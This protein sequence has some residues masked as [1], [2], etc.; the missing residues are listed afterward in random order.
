MKRDSSM[1]GPSG[2]GR[3]GA[4]L[5]T[6]WL[7][8]IPGAP[9]TANATAPANTTGAAN[10]TAPINATAPASAKTVNW[11]TT[12]SDSAFSQA[13]R[14]HKFVLLDLHAVWCHW[15][16]MMDT[17]TYADP[18]VQAA[19][20]KHYVAVSVDADS[21]PAL[22]SRYGDWGWPATIVLAADGTEI[23]KRRGYIAPAQMLSLLDA[24]VADPSPGPSVGTAL[25]VGNTSATSLA[26][27]D[28]AALSETA[29]ALYDMANAGWGT[30][31]KYLDASAMEWSFA[32]LDAGNQLAMTKVRRTLDANQNLIDPVWGGV[33]QYS[34]QVDWKSPHYEKLLSYQADD[35]RIYSEA[36]SRWHRKTDLEAAQKLYSY[37]T[38]FL[39]APDGG[40][41]VSQD[42]DVS[43]K[44]AG[45][46]FYA[47]DDAAR[48][49]AGMPKV[50]VH[51]YSRETGWA[52]RALC[53]YYD[54]TGDAAALTRAERG[55]KWALRARQIAGGGFS[56]D[57]IGGDHHDNGGGASHGGNG[58][59]HHDNGGGASHGGNGGDHHDNGGGASH[60]GNG[61]DHHD[62]GGGA[63]HGGN[64]GDHHDNG[65]GASHGG[66]AGDHHDNGGGASHG[67]NAS[68]AGH[69]STPSD[70]TSADLTAGATQSAG[71]SADQAT[72]APALPGPFLDDSVSMTQAFLALYR[73]TGNREWLK[74]AVATLNFI[75]T[76]LRDSRAG[77]MASSP[78]PNTRGVFREPVRDV[79]QNAAVARAASMLHHYTAAERHLHIARHAM[80]YLSA[81]AAAASDQFRPD[82]LLADHEL[83]VAP[84]HITIVGGKD[85]PAAQ[86]LHAAALQY[87]TEYL[88]VDWW[89]RRE[90]KLPD[91]SIT[92]P[93]LKRPAAFACTANACS[94]PVYEASEIQERVRS[95]L[96]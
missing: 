93:D 12:W 88:Q 42:A 74:A 50:D 84:I 2:K 73:S 46:E 61:G 8:W 23:V 37:L 95:V 66:N 41:Y 30:E 7:L 45:H 13:A 89:D 92:Y 36:Y 54:V 65:G 68:G 38:T 77:Y 60:G 91:P 26:E 85:D 76:Q 78:I 71:R 29:D 14:E 94:T 34:D 17:T 82:I 39:S 72:G 63:S 48:R 70:A 58:G 16:H 90:G 57:G 19:I 62:N 86:S 55:A 5:A 32:T 44:M 83:S 69:V 22:T 40:F 24:I 11:R 79:A 31:H 3:L 25:K 10:A 53:K 35:L 20:A 64:G 67:G 28:R 21:D 43:T 9:T 51:E 27:K 6:T 56:H 1:K 47:K 96:N 18:A 81:F 49:A 87:P 59:D 4:L 15:C 33:F 52:I 80:K 75:D